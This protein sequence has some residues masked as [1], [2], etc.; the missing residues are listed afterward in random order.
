MEIKQ[1]PEENQDIKNIKTF[2]QLPREIKK[3][4]LNRQILKNPTFEHYTARYI[5]A[6][7]FQTNVN[8]KSI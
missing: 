7:E 2:F 6:T 8:M 4:N 1:Q 5:P 3:L